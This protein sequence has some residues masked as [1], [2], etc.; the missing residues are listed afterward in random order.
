MEPLCSVGTDKAAPWGLG[1]GPSGTGLAAR[2]TDETV[3]TTAPVHYRDVQAVSACPGHGTE[4][5]AVGYYNPYQRSARPLCEPE[6][7]RTVPAPSTVIFALASSP[8]A[9]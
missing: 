9:L 7:M 3:Q 8:K 4:W 2:Q 1:S 5:T 6:T